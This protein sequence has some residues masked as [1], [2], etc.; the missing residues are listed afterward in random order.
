MSKRCK[1]SIRQDKPILIWVD[2]LM[3]K[4][5]LV[6]CDWLMEWGIVCLIPLFNFHL[7]NHNCLKF[8]LIV[9]DSAWHASWVTACAYLSVILRCSGYICCKWCDTVFVWACWWYNKLSELASASLNFFAIEWGLGLNCSWP[10]HFLSIL[11]ILGDLT[12]L[13]FILVGKRS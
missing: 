13:L 7:A 11:L 8:L 2:L 12:E 3:C 1:L 4:F 10:Y 6:I 9:V 5:L